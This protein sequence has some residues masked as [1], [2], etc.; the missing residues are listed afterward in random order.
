MR[1]LAL[2]P[3]GTHEHNPECEMLLVPDP[4]GQNWRCLGCGNL[5]IMR[6][7]EVDIK[8]VDP[9]R[10]QP[11]QKVVVMWEVD[12]DLVFPLCQRCKKRTCVDDGRGVGVCPEC[13][14]RDV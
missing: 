11:A 10:A 1:I 5:L 4:D 13:G 8:T 12:R 14:W 2:D 3:K 7:V 9:L 6:S